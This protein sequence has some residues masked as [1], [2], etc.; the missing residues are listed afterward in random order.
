M[1]SILEPFPAER[2]FP[3]AGTGFLDLGDF[4]DAD[5]LSNVVRDRR[6]L[7]APRRGGPGRA[8]AARLAGTGRAGGLAAA[9]TSLQL[10]WG[11]VCRGPAPEHRV[12]RWC[13]YP[14]APRRTRAAFPGTGPAA[15]RGDPAEESQFVLT[16]RF[17]ET[18]G[19]GISVLSQAGSAQPAVAQ[20][21]QHRGHDRVPSGGRPL[22]SA[23][24]LLFACNFSSEWHLGDETSP[25]WH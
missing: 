21:R 23:P 6:Q 22:G 18:H 4:S 8:A 5:F 16:M 14:G 7:P 20:L 25:A 10:P 2:L 15:P 1:D 12:P 3:A 17:L 19:W 24:P 11:C 13:G 9:P